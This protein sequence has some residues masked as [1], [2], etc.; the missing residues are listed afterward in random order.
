MTKIIKSI[1]GT[2]LCIAIVI[3]AGIVGSLE[4]ELIT[5]NTAVY[6]GVVWV[7]VSVILMVIY[8]TA[9]NIEEGERYGIGKD[10]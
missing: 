9:N 1:C 7:L 6:F 8:E 4:N 2:L 3:A 10:F 5:L